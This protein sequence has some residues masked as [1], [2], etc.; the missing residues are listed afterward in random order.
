MRR[1]NELEELFGLNPQDRASQWD[2][3]DPRAERGS[4][5]PLYTRMMRT[6]Q[7]D[8]IQYQT[9]SSTGPTNPVV[10]GGNYADARSCVIYV[11]G[12]N[13][14]YR[15]DGQPPTAA[16]DQLIQQ[17]STI[18]LTGKPTMLGFIFA[19][20]IGAVTLYATYYD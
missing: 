11:G 2:V 6:Y 16:G 3:D 9:A 10:L 4:M 18:T 17:G 15:V 7:G 1:S 20:A 14:I 8:P 13:I 5:V 19:G 12:G